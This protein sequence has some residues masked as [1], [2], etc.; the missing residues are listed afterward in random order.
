MGKRDNR[1]RFAVKPAEVMAQYWDDREDESLD[2]VVTAAALVARADRRIEAA[3]RSQILDFLHRDGS[4]NIFTPAEILEMFEHR[5]RELNE[6]GGPVGA[7]KQLRRHAEHSL[8]RVIMNAGQEV[9]AADHRIDPREQHILQLI[10]TTLGGPLPRLAAR[11]N[12]L[13]KMS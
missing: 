8:A 10:W 9:A 11:P 4:L 3:E 13:G 2:A 5:V 1:R 12:R 6:P 7:L